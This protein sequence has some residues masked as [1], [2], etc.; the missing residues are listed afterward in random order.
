MPLIPFRRFIT[1]RSLLRP[2]VKDKNGKIS[3]GMAGATHGATAKRHGIKDVFTDSDLETGYVD[4]KGEFMD[5][6]KAYKFA[7]Q[8]FLLSKT[9]AKDAYE[10][11]SKYP[12]QYDKQP[13]DT[14]DLA[15]SRIMKNW[16]KSFRGT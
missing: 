3:I 10:M 1:E 13:L 16:R 5:R 7:H 14:T 6:R 8:N 2:A 15:N 9:A 11:Y 4:R 12:D